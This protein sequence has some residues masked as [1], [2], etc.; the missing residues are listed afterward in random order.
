MQ[1]RPKTVIFLPQL[2]ASHLENSY[3]CLDLLGILTAM[4]YCN[5]LHLVP[6]CLHYLH[7]LLFEFNSIHWFSPSVRLLTFTQMC[8]SHSCTKKI[9]H[10]IF[11][12]DY[13]LC[14]S[15]LHSTGA[16]PHNLHFI[17]YSQRDA[18]WF[19][20]AIWISTCWP[21]VMLCSNFRGYMI[22]NSIETCPFYLKLFE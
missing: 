18:S 22:Y 11:N 17:P 3:F 21:T 13:V 1:N 10:P 15:D 12:A 16:S 6:Q 20:I 2:E 19:G 14:C 5:W 4:L 9:I 7:W 8:L